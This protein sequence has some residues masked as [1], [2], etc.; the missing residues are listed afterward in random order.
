LKS[1]Y[2]VK[3]KLK[4]GNNNFFCGQSC[5]TKWSNEVRGIK[6]EKFKMICKCEKEFETSTR[7]RSKRHCSPSC[8]SKYSV[9]KKRR[10]GN[11]KGGLTCASIL[12]HSEKVHMT[13]NAMKNRE[14]WKYVEINKFLL[15]QKED[16]EFELPLGNYIFDL[17]IKS[18]MLIIEFDAKYHNDPIQSKTDFKK[19]QIAKE[20]GWEL[21]RIETE[22]NKILQP[23]LLYD[24][25]S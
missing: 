17:A 4:N 8:A 22:S 21:I 12:S 13:S 25:L 23:E 19:D 24:I 9:T 18:R 1:K 16:F 11:R 15:F 2:E 3:R 20:N 10:E 14:A 5:S 7:R 6:S